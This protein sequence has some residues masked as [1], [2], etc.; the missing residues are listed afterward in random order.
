LLLGSIGGAK[1]A[2][3]PRAGLIFDFGDQGISTDLDFAAI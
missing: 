2:A 3:S 1:G